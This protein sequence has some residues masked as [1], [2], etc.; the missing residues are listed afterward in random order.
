MCRKV[1]IN[2][3]NHNTEND[4]SYYITYKS[5]RDIGKKI[6]KE[7][8]FSI[9]DLFPNS[10]NQSY[11]IQD[12]EYAIPNEYLPDNFQNKYIKV[13]ETIG[14]NI[15]N[16]LIETRKKLLNSEAID[17][18]TL[19]KYKVEQ[20]LNT[21]EFL[22]IKEKIY[23]IKSDEV[24]ILQSLFNELDDNDKIEFDYLPC[25]IDKSSIILKKISWTKY[26]IRLKSL[27]S[28]NKLFQ[29]RLS[30]EIKEKDIIYLDI[31]NLDNILNSWQEIK[32][33]KNEKIDHE[34][35]QLD[36]QEKD[37]E[38]TFKDQ[39]K[40]SDE[41]R[42][43]IG[44][45]GEKYIYEK[46]IEKFS[47]DKVI[48]HNK[49]VISIQDDRGGIDI[50]IKDNDNKIIHNIEIKT[51]IKSTSMDNSVS[52]TLSSKQFE[53]ATDWGRDTHL[54]FVTGIEDDEPKVLYMNFD[55]N[56]LI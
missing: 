31:L 38:A 9:S 40:D 2:I 34:K 4:D 13:F 10:L 19:R 3:Y 47:I 15:D 44:W 26:F 51:T 20:I 25:L 54:V 23:K 7:A 48:W 16:D 22:R 24:K 49:K 18:K 43:K 37:I 28:K 46:L 1:W 29:K 42:W 36:E 21:I 45:K 56:W 6:M 14:L 32:E 50:E 11:Y 39:D 55:N 12:A 53:A 52:F 27:K 41:Y 17:R 8:P 5:L 30:N 33:N 35:Q